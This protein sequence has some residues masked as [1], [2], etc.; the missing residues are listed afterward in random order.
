[1]SRVFLQ[2][3]ATLS[4]LRFLSGCGVADTAG[5]QAGDA[6]TT[7]HVTVRECPSF[8]N[9]LIFPGELPLGEAAFVFALAEEPKRADGVAPILVYG[10]E[11]TSGSFSAPAQPYTDYHCGDVGPQLLTA[12]AANP[13]G[14]RVHLTLPVTC[15]E[16]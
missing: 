4:A 13:W 14:C 1:M 7:V 8:T 6:P 10:W 3:F 5:E 2:T 15:L 9:H 12:T 16:E 11:A